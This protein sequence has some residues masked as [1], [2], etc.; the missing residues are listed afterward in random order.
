VGFS[1]TARRHYATLKKHIKIICSI[2]KDRRVNG[3][4]EQKIKKTEQ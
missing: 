3:K 1:G 2:T 4:N